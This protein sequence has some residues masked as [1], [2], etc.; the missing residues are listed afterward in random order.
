VIDPKVRLIHK[1]SRTARKN[2]HWVASV[3]R[4]YS[5]VYYRN[6]HR[7]LRNRAAFAWLICGFGML[8]LAACI[9]RFSLAPWRAFTRA[10]EYG[11]SVGLARN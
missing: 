1:V 5:Y 9:R 8:S 6:W 11:K 2:E 10:L 7:G 3:M 4:G